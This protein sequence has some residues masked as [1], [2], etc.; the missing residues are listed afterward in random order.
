MS[1]WGHVMWQKHHMLPSKFSTLSKYER[2][3]II[4]SE[5]IEYKN[6]KKGGK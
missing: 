3:F 4:A 2:D 1:S 5:L 6:Q